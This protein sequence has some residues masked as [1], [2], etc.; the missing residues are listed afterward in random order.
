MN[1][2]HVL[3]LSVSLLL[4]T[5]Y[6]GELLYNNVNTKFS[7]SSDYSIEIHVGEFPKNAYLR[8]TGFAITDDGTYA[9]AQHVVAGCSKTY[10]SY[11]GEWIKADS[12]K[13][14]KNSDVAILHIPEKTRPVRISLE[15]GQAQ[16]VK[17]TGFPGE[18]AK[19]FQKE[20]DY[21]VTSKFKV[22]GLFTV[23]TVGDVW[24][25]D[26][27]DQ[28]KEHIRGKYQ[29]MSGGPALDNQGYADGVIVAESASDPL[30]VTMLPN[31][32]L[33]LMTNDQIINNQRSTK[34]VDK[35]ED[36][37]NNSSITEIMCR[38]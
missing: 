28:K 36:M 9:T 6:D 30:I 14:H 17:I 3:V 23:N 8:G 34:F 19:F 15:D 21:L 35:T 33:D 26:D 2:L 4:F 1:K 24:E 32:V 11:H 31:D 7:K 18:D 20:A 16:I 12:V 37:L 29:G 38:N 13:K 25:V 5:V 22:T 10:V 27:V